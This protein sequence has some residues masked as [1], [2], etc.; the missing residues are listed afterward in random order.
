MFDWSD[1]KTKIQSTEEWLQKEFTQIRTGRATPVILDFIQVDAYGNKMGIKEVA[2]IIVEDSRT[3]KVE[4]W[5]I[6]LGKNIE[7]GIINSNLGLSVSPYDK[8]IRII[9][10]ELTGERREQFVKVVK[11]KLEEARVAL[12]GFRDKT[13]KLI[14]EKEKAGGMSEDQKFRLKEEMQ[15]MIEGA[16][17]KME[18]MA[19]KKESEIRN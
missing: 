18:E 9:F 17:T 1:L 8:G 15:K 6:G 2:N 5:D 12:R 11:A 19:I 4:P 3:I 14:D 10:P 7:K 16:N 13:S